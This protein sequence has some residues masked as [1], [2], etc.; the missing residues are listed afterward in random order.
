MTN[1]PLNIMIHFGWIVF[2]TD[3][4]MSVYFIIR[5]L[6]NNVPPGYTSMI[7]AISFFGSLIV[8]LLGFIGRYL[9][10]IY[11]EV[12]RRPLYTIKKKYNL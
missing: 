2:V 3:I 7:L 12:R 5:Y 11:S 1:A 6:F 8:L 10:N 4:I 9:S